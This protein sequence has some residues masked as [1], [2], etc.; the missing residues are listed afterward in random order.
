MLRNV[1]VRAAIS[2]HLADGGIQKANVELSIA[3]IALG[4]DIADFEAW[5]KGDKTLVQLRAD[6][7][8]T[9]LIESITDITSTKQNN[10]DTET[11]TRKRRIKLYSRLNALGLLS[12]VFGMIT[13]KHKHSGKIEGAPAGLL[14]T[15]QGLEEMSDEELARIARTAGL[16]D[17]STIG[18]GEGGG[19]VGDSK[20]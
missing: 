3:K 12:R 17:D 15:A 10:D 8:E 18:D 20:T 16:T 4:S 7:V 5:W 6:G 19:A 1:K 11:V 2:E 13:D 9:G 14:I